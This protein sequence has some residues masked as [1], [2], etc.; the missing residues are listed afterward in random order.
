MAGE[1]PSARWAV[2][3]ISMRSGKY[4]RAENRSSCA[5]TNPR[6]ASAAMACKRPTTIMPKKKGGRAPFFS[7][8]RSAAPP[9][10]P[11]F[12]VPWL[13]RME[14]AHGASELHPKRHRRQLGQRRHPYAAMIESLDSSNKSTLSLSPFQHFNDK[15]NVEDLVKVERPLLPL[16]TKPVRRESTPNSRKRYRHSHSLIRPMNK[17]M[18]LISRRSNEAKNHAS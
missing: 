4:Q 2:F 14:S 18:N 15:G 10:S 16:T 11:H 7:A 1:I 5:R 6:Y 13:L 8:N 3:L 17:Q 9:A 12:S